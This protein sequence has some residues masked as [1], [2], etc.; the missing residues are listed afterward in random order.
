MYLI[1]PVCVPTPMPRWPGHVHF[2]RTLTGLLVVSG[3]AG[4][5]QPRKALDQPAL[6]GQARGGA[7]AQWNGV[8]GGA[9]CREFVQAP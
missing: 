3:S 6:K 9:P 7:A 2:W 1:R 8:H 5:R 4:M